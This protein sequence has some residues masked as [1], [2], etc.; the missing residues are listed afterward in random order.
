MQALIT[1]RESESNSPISASELEAFL[2]LAPGSLN[3]PN[4]DDA[5]EGSAIRQTFLAN[6]GDV[7]SFDFNFLT[8]EVLETPFNDFGFISLNGSVSELADT[9]S[10]TSSVATTSFIE[11]TGFQTFSTAISTTGTYTLGIGVVDVGDSFIS[12]VDY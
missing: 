7:I 8:N 3:Q 11:E 5:T 9:T 12:S 2:D 4:N 1:N 10:A 6:A